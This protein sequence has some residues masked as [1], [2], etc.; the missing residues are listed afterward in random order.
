MKIFPSKFEIFY[1]KQYLGAGDNLREAVALAQEN[2]HLNP[3]SIIIYALYE[4]TPKEIVPKQFYCL[5]NYDFYTSR[6]K[7]RWL[8]HQAIKS[9]EEKIFKIKSNKERTCWK[10]QR[11]LNFDDFFYTNPSLGKEKALDLWEAP[12]VELLCCGCFHTYKEQFEEELRR[13]KLERYRQI[14][15]SELNS[16]GKRALQ[17]LEA[18]IG[19]SV[20]AAVIIDDRFRVRNFGFIAVNGTVVGLSLYY[21]SLTHLP[22]TL[23][24][25]PYLE[26]L[27]LSGNM[28]TELP[29]WI[30]SLVSL[31]YM[32]L[33]SNKL[34]HIP[35]SIQALKNLEVLDLS[36]NQLASLP[37]SLIKL[38][39]L[40]YLY[41]WANQISSQLPILEG[42]KKNGINIVM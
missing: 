15:I 16:Q 12:C 14:Q 18:Q 6:I 2:G 33:L 17:K 4:R 24:E 7:T 39:S 27:D 13:E 9:S 32:K 8:N 29:E 22:E 20:P 1:E 25:F 36:G 26:Y 34:T 3:D 21:Y 11:P 5:L 35:D 31:K 10:C 30:D 42:L 41:L 40:K 28:L 38:P 19:K 23:C 37:T